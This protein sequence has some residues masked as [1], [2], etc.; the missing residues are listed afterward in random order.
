MALWEVY[1]VM[2]VVGFAGVLDVFV[3]LYVKE[4]ISDLSCIFS[5]AIVAKSSVEGFG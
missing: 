1:I 2:K 4:R 3:S 5:L